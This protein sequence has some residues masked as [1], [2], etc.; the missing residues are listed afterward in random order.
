M[1]FQKDFAEQRL[2]WIVM[3]L[4]FKDWSTHSGRVFLRHLTD[5]DHIADDFGDDLVHGGRRH[6]KQGAGIHQVAA[7]LEHGVQRQ[8]PDEGL[9]PAAAAV[10]DVFL[11]FDPT[12]GNERSSINRPFRP[13]GS[14]R[15]NAKDFQVIFLINI[16]RNSR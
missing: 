8:R 4:D 6:V 16:N 5:G 11:E 9:R 12:V 3:E 10:L 7:Q 2:E 1:W 15:K 13:Q 14:M